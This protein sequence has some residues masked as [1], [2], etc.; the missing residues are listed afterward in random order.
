MQLGDPR[1]IKE[2]LFFGPCSN[3]GGYLVNR[4]GDRY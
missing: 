2:L 3:G 1:S 4:Y